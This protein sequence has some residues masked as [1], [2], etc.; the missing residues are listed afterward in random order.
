MLC[1]IFLMLFYGRLVFAYFSGGVG[2]GDFVFPFTSE[3]VIESCFSHHEHCD[4]VV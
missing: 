1:N 2:W 4:V 3:I